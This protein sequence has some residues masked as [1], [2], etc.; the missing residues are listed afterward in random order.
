MSQA[1]LAEHI[2]EIAGSAQVSGN[3]VQFEYAGVA[4]ASVS[5]ATHD[6]MRLIAA[7]VRVESLEPAHL[8]A[9]LVA[10][11]HTTLDARYALS[12]AIR[13]VYHRP[14]CSN[15]SWKSA[16]GGVSSHQ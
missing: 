16:S 15:T 10:N 7:I 8:A 9:L 14:R 13:I 1:A 5:D 4:I 11:F 2:E 3:V 6:R 12:S